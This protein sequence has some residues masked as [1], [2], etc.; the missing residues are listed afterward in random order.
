MFDQSESKQ[1][2]FLNASSSQTWMTS[3]CI[4]PVWSL[5]WSFLIW[6]FQCPTPLANNLSD[7]QGFL[8]CFPH[9]N[10]RLVTV[11]RSCHPTAQSA[12]RVV[13]ADP[14]SFS[15]AECK[16]RWPSRQNMTK[17]SKKWQAFYQKSTSFSNHGPAQNYI[18]LPRLAPPPPKKKEKCTLT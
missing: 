13:A 1:I 10:W 14:P 5:G 15:A 18:T 9:L 11:P 16:R 6:C 3:W 17:T 8:C 4:N 7:H 12:G 2:L